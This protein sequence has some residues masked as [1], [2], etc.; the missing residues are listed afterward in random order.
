LIINIIQLEIPSED[1]PKVILKSS[2]S[3]STAGASGNFKTDFDPF[4]PHITRNSAQPVRELSVT[5]QKLKVL[6]KRREILEGS[7]E[8]VSRETQVIVPRS[9]ESTDSGTIFR[10]SSV[11][12]QEGEGEGYS[13]KNDDN[14]DTEEAEGGG[15]RNPLAQVL[16]QKLK[17]GATTEAPLTT[18]AIR[19]LEKARKERIYSKTLIRV[20]FPDKVIIQG[21]FHPKDSVLSVYKW[22]NSCLVPELQSDL[23]F[24]FELKSSP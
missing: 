20:K 3:V 11:S 14:E 12:S 15:S 9:A 7:L 1:F 4:K 21:Y 13:I 6:E 8:S 22:A 10:K 18:R 16:S 5:E 23:E 2:V 24:R 19:E 17:G